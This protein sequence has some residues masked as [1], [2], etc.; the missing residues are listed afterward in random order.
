MKKNTNYQIKL[1]EDDE[2]NIDSSIASDLFVKAVRRCLENSSLSK[3][4]QLETI[5]K[6]INH[7][8]SKEQ[9]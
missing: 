8:K 3:A 2:Q 7:F 4:E 1:V 5:D 6:L 9:A